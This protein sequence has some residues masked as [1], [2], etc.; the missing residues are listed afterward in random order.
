MMEWIGEPTLRTLL[1]EAGADRGR[2]GALLGA[3]GRWLREFH[4]QPEAARRPLAEA[5]LAELAA[6]PLARAKRRVRSRTFRR[7]RGA[8]D[9]CLA[10]CGAAEV[11]YARCHGD[12]VPNN[13]FHGRGRT[14]VIDLGLDVDAPAT[15]DICRLLVRAETTKP[16]LTRRSTLAP[17]G[18]EGADLE[19]FLAAYDEGGAPLPRDTLAVAL[20]AEIL[21]RWASIFSRP[22]GPLSYGRWLKHFRLRRMARMAAANAARRCL[23]A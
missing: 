1:A 13:I 23:G 10:A 20:L 19:A 17:E 8:L 6:A 22:E 2:R 18:I 15:L 4:R 21:H 14:T 5:R 11:P 12:F 3:A 16:F 9:D 7:A